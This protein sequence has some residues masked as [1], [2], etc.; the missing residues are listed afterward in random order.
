MKKN[1]LIKLLQSI[2]GNPDIKLWNGYVHDYNDINPELHSVELVKET[3]EFLYNWR[4]W[5][6][7]KSN[8]VPD[9]DN[10]PQEV[11]DDCM[12]K[13]RKS[14]KTRDWEFP[15][16]HVDE[17]SFEKWY[18][19]KRKKLVLILPRERGKISYGTDRGSDIPY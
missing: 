8:N 12:A 2:D 5:D 7:M 16:S 17:E 19:K 4:L 15:N 11:K 1:D 6:W 18:G 3:V 14:H 9:E 10:V 13:A